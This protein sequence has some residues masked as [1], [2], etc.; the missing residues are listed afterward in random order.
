MFITGTKGTIE[1]RKFIDLTRS[2]S[3]EHLFLVNE[4]GEKYFHLQNKIG[5]PFFEKMILDCFK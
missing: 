1:I 5:F 4:H 3:G 2:S